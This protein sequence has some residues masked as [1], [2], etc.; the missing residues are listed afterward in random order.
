MSARI[1]FGVVSGRSSSAKTSRATR[2]GFVVASFSRTAQAKNPL[3]VES[4]FLAVERERCEAVFARSRMSRSSSNTLS[5]DVHNIALPEARIRDA[6]TGARWGRAGVVPD[7]PC[8]PPDTLT[9][10][11]EALSAISRG[12]RSPA[13]V[14]GDPVRP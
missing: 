10:A 13:C 6:V 11:T 9:L 8:K 3:A 2:T 7:I 12:W 5:Q 4:T 1:C 14:R